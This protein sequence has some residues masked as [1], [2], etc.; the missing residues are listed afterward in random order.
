MF[1]TNVIRLNMNAITLTNAT[2]SEMRDYAEAH[3]QE[4]SCDEECDVEFAQ[5]DF[6]VF[7]DFR[8]YGHLEEEDDYHNEFGYNNIEHRSWW[9]HDN[10]EIASIAAYDGDGEEY[11]VENYDF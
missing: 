7:A 10:S 1:R 6:F 5:G 4:S 11:E 9:E 2:I 3:K 8:H